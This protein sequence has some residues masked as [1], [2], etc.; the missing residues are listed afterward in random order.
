MGHPRGLLG[1]GLWA[2]NGGHPDSPSL[3]CTGRPPNT[4]APTSNGHRSSRSL[5][6]TPA[7]SRR[8][9]R[10]LLMG[11]H[12]RCGSKLDLDHR[13]S[14]QPTRRTRLE[15]R[16]FGRNRREVARH[17]VR[18]LRSACRGTSRCRRW[19]ARRLYG[20]PRSPLGR[21]SL[22]TGRWML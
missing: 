7:S 16:L 11:I 10:G 6:G 13:P 20:R 18:C 19:F 1:I 22:Q 8:G 15:P 17:R 9:P 3:S 2:S 21:T 14:R 5:F 12:I 4:A